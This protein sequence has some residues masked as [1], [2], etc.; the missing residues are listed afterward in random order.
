MEIDLTAHRRH[1]NAVAI[2]A[3]AAHYAVNQVAHL[4]MIR[5]PE[6]KRIE[7]RNWPCAHR[8]DIAE[9]TANARR[10]ALIR[11][12]VARVIMRLHLENRGQFLAIWP[13]TN[14]NHARIF[15]GA[16]DHLWASG[17]QFLQ[18]NPRAF[19]GAMLR[20]HHR[21]YTK[22]C[23]IGLT[24]HRS[25]NAHIFFFGKAVFGDDLWGNFGHARAL[26]A[27]CDRA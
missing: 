5:P 20:P 16:A 14:I 8:E 19:V 27:R 25:K 1:T 4:G 6:A 7:V 23:Q 12:N 21:E 18:M 10:R 11:F 24:A 9:D 2:A 3:D 13:I 26:T 17:W 22:L 15:A